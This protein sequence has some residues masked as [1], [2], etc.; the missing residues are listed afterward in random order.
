[1]HP[2]LNYSIPSWGRGSNAAIQPLIKLQNKGI[3][4]INPTNTGSLEEHFQHLNIFCLPKLY[5]F[6]V[7]KFMHSYHNKLLP[8]HLIILRNIVFHSAQFIITPQD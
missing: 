5:G 8:N 7:G 1:M 2:Y 6:S 3:K 4:I